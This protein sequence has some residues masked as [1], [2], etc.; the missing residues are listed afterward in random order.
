MEAAVRGFYSNSAAHLPPSWMS[1]KVDADCEFDC[2]NA[3]LESDSNKRHILT[4]QCSEKPIHSNL[5]IYAWRR[6]A[7]NAGSTNSRIA[8]MRRQVL[9]LF[10]AAM[11]ALMLGWSPALTT[12]EASACY[13][14][15][16]CEGTIDDHSSNPGWLTFKNATNTTV[17]ITVKYLTRP[18]AAGMAG[19]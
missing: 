10:A 8:V 16:D 6:I 3:V 2:R 18:S 19:K 17:W 9:R 11:L 14:F 13:I 12:K 4:D 1:S 15:F 5:P 7:M